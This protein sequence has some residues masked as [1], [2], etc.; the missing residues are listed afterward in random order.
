MARLLS[1][2][3]HSDPPSG[4][5]DSKPSTGAGPTLKLLAILA[6][7]MVG[8]GAFYWFRVGG[9]IGERTKGEWKEERTRLARIAPG[10]L[11]WESNRSGAWR[12]WTQ[13]LDGSGVK[14]LTPEEEG[15]DHFCPHLAP[16]GGS[17]VYMSYPR[18]KNAYDPKETAR[19]MWLNLETKKTQVLVEE[20]RSYQEDRAVVW[21]GPDTFFY[22]AADG[23]SRAHTVGKEV[24]EDLENVLV[25]K[26]HSDRGWLLDPTQQ[27][28]TTGRPQFGFWDGK[29]KKVAFTVTHEGSQP[30]FTEEGRWAYWLGGRGG[31]IK[32]YDLHFGAFYD[33]IKRGDER[34]PAAFPGVGFPKISSNHR[35]I[36]FAGTRESDGGDPFKT[37]YE[38]FVGH[39]H[40]VSLELIG[41]PVR[42]TFNKSCDRFPDVY[43]DDPPMKPQF[44]ELPATLSL[45]VQGESDG[46]WEW[47]L[48]GDGEK[49]EKGTGRLTRTIEEPGE[50]FITAR[51]K[52]RKVH[53][54]A[55]ARKQSPPEVTELRRLDAR[56]LRVKFSEL[57][58]FPSIRARLKSGGKIFTK[59]NADTPIFT[60]E[61]DG[62][63]PGGDVLTLSG[64]RDF[65]QETNTMK[66]FEIRL[67]P[68]RWPQENPPPVFLW[69]D[70]YPS[71]KAGRS[72]GLGSWSGFSRTTKRGELLVENG[73]LIFPPEA[74]AAVSK[75]CRASGAFTIEATLVPLDKVGAKPVS[76]LS[77]S[78][79]SERRNLTLAQV[80]NNL[81]LLL[82]T[83]DE[84]NGKDKLWNHRLGVMDKRKENRIAV[85][86]RDGDLHFYLNGAEVWKAQKIEGGLS[87]WHDD[88]ELTVGTNTTKTKTLWHGRISGL[89]IYDK[90]LSPEQIGA[91]LAGF[92][93][94]RTEAG[95]A[96]IEPEMV[97]RAKLLRTSAIPP[98]LLEREEKV[99]VVNEYKSFAKW[100]GPEALDIDG[101]FYVAH[102]AKLGGT[103]T[104]VLDREPGREG[105]YLMS[106]FH[107]NHQLEGI[108][109]ANDFAGEISDDNFFYDDTYNY[110]PEGEEPPEHE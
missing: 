6:L 51:Q 55:L 70:P 90:V 94:Q 16:N 2:N 34:M 58:S 80:G 52:D 11:V 50:Y 97:S 74:G 40:P 35:L 106:P 107:E 43:C 83:R 108:P 56:T 33:L 19:L 82:R 22:I 89:A 65:A 39:L 76:I 102:W 15:R 27:F 59:G 104:S 69:R 30:Y 31:P 45:A 47:D 105:L 91:G 81:T 26:P 71:G 62:M 4:G 10:F 85:T 5:P 13:R 9:Q 49:L 110:W 60:V 20:A 95:I 99:L 63:D 84:K 78:K 67:P 72:H 24:R 8:A 86:Y 25:T 101:V 66:P 3:S 98:A 88:V 1:P 32:K 23:R 12:V 42:F 37:D 29:E 79:G 44:V 48:R 103:R 100:A 38:I 41:K 87:N 7:L 68:L 17:M 64:A 57:V 36:A 18:G 46:S 61:L 54:Y 92:E 14:Q 28:A 75:A 21:T 73:G 77:L 96:R 109:I 53:G 93:Y